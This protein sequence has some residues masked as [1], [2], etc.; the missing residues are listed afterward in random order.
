M[1][2]DGGGGSD[3]RFQVIGTAVADDIS[4]GDN[5]STLIV[6]GVP[7]HAQFELKNLNR[8]WVQGPRRQ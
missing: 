2:L 7:L 6:G 8:M 5:P 4:I 3:N 1:Q